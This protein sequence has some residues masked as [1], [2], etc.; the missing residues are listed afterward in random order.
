MLKS[1]HNTFSVQNATTIKYHSA[2]YTQL[3]TVR[4]KITKLHLYK[5]FQSAL[6]IK[7]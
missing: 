7:C 4:I 3:C 6:Y 2:K 5:K 1:F